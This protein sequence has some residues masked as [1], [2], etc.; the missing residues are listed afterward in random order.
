MFI[1]F[2][3][4]MEEV[5][6]H[7]VIYV[8]TVQCREHFKHNTTVVAQFANI[9]CWIF[10][11]KNEYNEIEFVKAVASAFVLLIPYLYMLLLLLL[12]FLPHLAIILFMLTRSP[13]P[14]TV[15]GASIRVVHTTKQQ[16]H[17]F[18]SHKLPL[19]RIVPLAEYVVQNLQNVWNTNFI[20]FRL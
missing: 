2:T 13:T 16:L 9:Y 20:M 10:S 6:H 4:H 11:D 19:C 15:G 17:P 8:K 12:C 3:K 5:N 1:R 14:H 18:H 7:N